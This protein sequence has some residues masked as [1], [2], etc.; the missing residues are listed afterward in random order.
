[1][2]IS[3][4]A[5]AALALMLVGANANAQSET[6]AKP[7]AADQS[8]QNSSPGSIVKGRALYEDTGQP[9]PRER[10]QLVA[11]ELL[12]NRRGPSR[13]P[14]TMTD[15]N[16]EFIFP[17]PGAGE[18]YVVA[19][20]VDEHVPSAEGSPFP[21]QTGDPVADAA[22]L[23]QYKRDFPRITVN[24]ESPV[25]INL[26]VKNP[27]FGSISGRIVSANGG[28]VAGANVHAMKTGERGFGASIVADENGAY[29]FR[30]LPAG[31]Y[32]VS[33]A[34]PSKKP[35]PERP[36]SVEGVLGSTYFPSTIDSRTS[37]PVVVSR[38]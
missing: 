35:G 26:R 19:H 34:P 21:L 10:V 7:R 1:M 29:R 22:R 37:P 28:P 9:A 2:R 14:T 11:I 17:H 6:A 38:P 25:E 27:H 3:K 16:G 20:P 30:G 18:Y 13:I 32:I 23:E 24:G 33:A 8:G 12:A 36:P 31:E 15:A 5:V 4:I